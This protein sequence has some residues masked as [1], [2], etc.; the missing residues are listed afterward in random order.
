M[1]DKLT[2]TTHEERA[3]ERRR[4]EEEER[5]TYQRHLKIRAAMAKAAE[6]GQPQ[7]VG[8]DRNGKDVY[9]EPPQGPGNGYGMQPYNPYGQGAYVNPNATYL[10]PNYPYARPYGYGYGGGMG[11]GYG[12]GL[13]L[14]TGLLGGML[15]GGLLF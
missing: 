9:I 6:T 12:S 11:Y 7:L 5:A 8:K 2:G 14:G 3:A 10:R 13:G 4:R 1:K 15:L